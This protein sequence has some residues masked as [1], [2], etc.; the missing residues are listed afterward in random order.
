MKR[1]TAILIAA[2]LLIPAAFAQ[3]PSRTS[4]PVRTGTPVP[5]TAIHM[6]PPAAGMPSAKVPGYRVVLTRGYAHYVS[7][8]GPE[9]FAIPRSE[10]DRRLEHERQVRRMQYEQERL[11]REARKL[12]E[13]LTR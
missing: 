4:V 8:T 7:E 12:G 1:T 2:L 13:L 3:T 6:A 10:Y 5:Q 9:H 11:L